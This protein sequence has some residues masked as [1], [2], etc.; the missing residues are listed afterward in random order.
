MVKANAIAQ[1]LAWQCVDMENPRWTGQNIH[2]QT[3]QFSPPNGRGV[4]RIRTRRARR[5]CQA[6]KVRGGRSRPSGRKDGV[7]KLRLA[8]MS[9]GSLE[10]PCHC[11]KGATMAT[12]T[13]QEAQALHL[14]VC[15]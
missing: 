4:R 13:Q 12:P 2:G 14:S 5:L 8:T 11:N 15:R 9:E 7:K 1:A 6:G 10:A 3:V